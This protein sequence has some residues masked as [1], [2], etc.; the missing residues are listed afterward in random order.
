M[1]EQIARDVVLV[2]TIEVTDDKREV[3]SDDDRMYAS[4]SAKELAQWQ[5]SDAKSAVTAEHFLQQRSEQILKRL[6]ERSPAFSVLAA[7]RGGWRALS[8]A[9]PLL[10][11]LAGAGLDRIGDPHRVDLLSAPLLGIIGWNLLVYVFLLVWMLVPSSS[12]TGWVTHGMLRSMAG[13]KGVLPRRLPNG[14]SVAL[15]E[16]MRQWTEMSA[17][18]NRARLSRALHLSA[19][20]F[21]LGAVASLYARGL[22]TEYRA[23]WESTFLNAEQVHT[24]L[25]VLFA[26]VLALSPLQGFTLAE[27]ESLRFSLP[28]SAAGGARWV[29]LYAGTLLLLVVLPRTLL[30]VMSHLRARKLQ[31]NF[32]IDLEQP[33]FR[34]LNDQLG[35]AAPALLRVLPY[36]FT[37]DEARDRGLSQVATMLFGEQAR[38]MLRPPCAYGDEPQQALGGAG[39]DDKDVTCTAVL[40]NLAATPEKENHGAFLDHLIRS[41]P[42]GIAVLIDESSLIERSDATRIAERVSLW[43]QFCSFHRAPVTVVN[44]LSPQSRPLDQN[45]GLSVSKAP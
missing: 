19:A 37:V 43:Q 21:A 26:P 29:H 45:A 28:A 17:P 9:L 34:K 3:L 44:L 32:P 24:I 39:T 20:T 4:R 15:T 22:M 27:I 14:M 18:L 30:A 25:S 23:G 16:F 41:S 13:A 1:N 36:S 33:Y 38:V 12:T 8:I 10:A 5:A 42:R 35:L 11:L 7:R 6:G 2:R 40:F 31:R